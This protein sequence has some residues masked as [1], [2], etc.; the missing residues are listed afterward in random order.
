MSD[1]WT[2]GLVQNVYTVSA[3]V[4][5]RDPGGLTVKAHAKPTKVAG[6][7]LAN[8]KDIVASGDANGNC[9]LNTPMSGRTIRSESRGLK[10]ED[11]I[12][13]KLLLIKC[14]LLL[15]QGLDLLLNGDL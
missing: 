2:S 13:S 14:L 7:V 15:L 11:L 4:S 12:R 10:R 8:A 9:A 5:A 1:V 6:L 3:A